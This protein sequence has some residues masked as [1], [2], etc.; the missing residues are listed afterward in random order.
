[1]MKAANPVLYSRISKEN[2]AQGEAVA[3]LRE[4]RKALRLLVRA[5]RLALTEDQSA[6]IDA[7]Q[8]ADTLDRWSEAAVTAT[9]A[10]GIFG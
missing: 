9:D 2:Y 6:Q 4:R 10:S 7:C 3:E 5:R 1:M 8:D